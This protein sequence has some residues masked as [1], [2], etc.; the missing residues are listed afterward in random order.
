M[1]DGALRY[2]QP[3]YFRSQ[4]IYSM[5]AASSLWVIFLELN[6][7]CY[8]RR[9]FQPEGIKISGFDFGVLVQVAPPAIQ[10][11]A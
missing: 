1:Y 11:L 3:N 6:R 9:E 7:R 10:Y 4:G 8:G 2:A 5:F